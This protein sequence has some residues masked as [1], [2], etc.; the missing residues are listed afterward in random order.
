LEK[1]MQVRNGVRDEE[2]AVKITLSRG[3]L[4]QRTGWSWEIDNP[5]GL[6]LDFRTNQNYAGMWM[7]GGEFWLPVLH[8]TE[9]FLPEEKQEALKELF[10]FFVG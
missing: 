2:T 4:K 6:I 9:Y 3:V 1:K 10:S 8:P 5:D 7:W